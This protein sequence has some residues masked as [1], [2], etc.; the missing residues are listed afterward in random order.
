MT[1]A[2]SQ[3]APAQVRGFD[4]DTGKPFSDGT[5]TRQVNPAYTRS[6]VLQPALLQRSFEIAAHLQLQ[7]AG[8]AS[9][10]QVFCHERL[11][12]QHHHWQHQ[13]ELYMPRSHMCS[14][15]PLQG[16]A[17]LLAGFETTASTL[18]FST[19][20]LVCA[21]HAPVHCCTLLLLLLLVVTVHGSKVY[22]CLN[23][24]VDQSSNIG[25]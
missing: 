19:Y 11:P 14:L 22:T 9:A 7:L 6:Y 23:A 5:I 2:Q 12:R 15:L 25:R 16:H 18:A 20:N 3:I 10:R 17:M 24:F 4:R 1:A 21:F 13:C 8:I